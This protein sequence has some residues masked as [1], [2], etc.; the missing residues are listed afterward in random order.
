MGRSTHANTIQNT[1]QHNGLLYKQETIIGLM[2][3]NMPY[4]RVSPKKVDTFEYSAK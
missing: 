3:Q 4:T 2:L 1:R